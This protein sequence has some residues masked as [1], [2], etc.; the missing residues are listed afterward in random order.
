MPARKLLDPKLDIVFKLLFTNPQ[1]EHLLR[2]FLEDF[3]QP[4]TPIIR[5]EVLNPE[6]K[7]RGAFER[8]IVDLMIALDGGK[9]AHVEIQ[10][11]MRP[12]FVERSLFYWARSFTGQLE[13]GVS[14]SS[15]KPTT[16]IFVLNYRELPGNY[17]YSVFQLREQ[18]RHTPLT[19]ALALHYL[20]LPKIP[21]QLL[22]A[23]DAEPVLKW[24]AFLSARSAEELHAFAMTDPIL[25][26]AEAALEH[27]SDDPIARE[28]AYRRELEV[29]DFNRLLELEREQGEAEGRIQGEVDA[30]AASVERLCVAFN[31]ELTA[32]RRS[33]LDTASARSLLELLAA[34]AE[35]HRWPE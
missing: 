30:L 22:T 16:G 12:G 32:T 10:L 9:R 31:I 28:Q 34:I 26:E 29:G 24:G 6:T 23:L 1:N 35:H 33:A 20:E 14:F 7:R 17:Y 4:D 2:C 8:A 25:R 11:Q 21:R 3:L 19:D 18:S 27:L 5:V 15:L 13:P